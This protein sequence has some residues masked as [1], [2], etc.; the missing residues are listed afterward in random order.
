MEA[1]LRLDSLAQELRSLG[2]TLLA[3]LTWMTEWS[4]TER[5]A[6]SSGGR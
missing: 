2:M 4:E 3:A 5:Q 6:E 1:I